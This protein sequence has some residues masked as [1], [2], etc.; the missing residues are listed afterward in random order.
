MD[1]RLMEQNKLFNLTEVIPLCDI[2]TIYIFTSYT[3]KIKRALNIMNPCLS[4]C[5]EGEWAV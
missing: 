2:I 5:L 4:L 3:T 1:D